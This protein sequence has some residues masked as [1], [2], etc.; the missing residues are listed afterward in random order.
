MNTH[1][2]SLKSSIDEK[3]RVCETCGKCFMSK[4]YF[5]IHRRIHSGENPYNCNVCDKSFAQK[6]HLTRHQ[7]THSGLKI[8]QCEV[9]KKCFPHRSSFHMQLF[10]LI[11]NHL[12]TKSV[13]NVLLKNL[14]YH[15][16]C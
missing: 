10:I 15:Y 3:Q 7:L 9:C 6:C 8:Y 1:Q 5:K 2:T 14:V 12:N 16:I 13:T 11:T 4:S